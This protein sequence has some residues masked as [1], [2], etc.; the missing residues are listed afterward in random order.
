MS[1]DATLP[2][3]IPMSAKDA[4]THFSGQ[5]PELKNARVTGELDLRSIEVPGPVR[6]HNCVFEGAVDA[7]DSRFDRSVQFTNCEFEKGL[8]LA[9]ARINGPLD[10]SGSV[11]KPANGAVHML[12]RD[13]HVEGCIEGTR[14][15]V[16]CGL[17][18]SD[19]E[20]GAALRLRGAEIRGDLMLDSALIEGELDFGDCEKVGNDPASRT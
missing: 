7:T 19:L 9:H 2:N 10:L 16:E 5:L 12:F 14:L 20:C 11:L 3:L 6:V 17:N 1:A 13:L 4:L 8:T 15:R 18:F